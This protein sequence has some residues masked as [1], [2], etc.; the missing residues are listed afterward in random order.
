L[1]ILN[2]TVIT[3]GNK[4]HMFDYFSVGKQGPAFMKESMNHFKDKLTDLASKV[5]HIDFWSD[6]GLKTYGTVCNV[7][8][9]SL[10]IKK[11]IIHHYFPP[12]HGHSR[13]DA[14]FGRGKRELR[15]NFPDGGLTE[16]I[17]VI[18]AFSGL[19]TTVTELLSPKIARQEGSYSQ[20]PS[21]KAFELVML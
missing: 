12:Y 15:K 14:H 4:E 18:E 1:S 21:G 13:C 17:Q 5:K 19:P 3:E 10:D 11:P 2:F 6:G 7:H 20:W 16:T 8:Q 9:L